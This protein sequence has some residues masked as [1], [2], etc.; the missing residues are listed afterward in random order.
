MSDMTQVIAPNSSQ[1]NSDDLIAGA[2]TITITSVSISGVEQPVVIN[3]VGDKGKPYKPCKS[4]CRIMVA[5]WGRDAKEYA[6][7]RMTLYR[8]PSVKWGGVEIGGIRISH[9]SHLDKPLVVAL[10]ATRGSR[11]PYTVQPLRV[12]KAEQAARQ[13]MT[14]YEAYFKGLPPPERKALVESGEHE[15]LKAIAASVAANAPDPFSQGKAAALAGNSRTD[16]PADF[17][18][19]ARAAWLKGFDEADTEAENNGE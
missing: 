10:T 11:K 17:D 5:A 14:S 7:R 18:E 3:F 4:M 8:D 9:L 13:G 16:C 2:M 6:G 19:P 12:S 1:I 15:A